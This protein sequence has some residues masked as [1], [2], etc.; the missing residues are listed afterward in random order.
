MISPLLI[1]KNQCLCVCP[2]RSPSP[3]L[4]VF[5]CVSFRAML[6]KKKMQG[7]KKQGLVG[8]LELGVEKNREERKANYEETG[9]VDLIV[10]RN[11]KGSNNKRLAN[12]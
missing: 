8:G 9:R 11:I 12:L 5:M 3:S 10:Q 6:L 2:C 1:S 4:C 7:R